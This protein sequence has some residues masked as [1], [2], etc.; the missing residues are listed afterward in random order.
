MKKVI[1]AVLVVLLAVA[2]VSASE[3]ELGVKTG[4]AFE[5]F[6]EK[7]NFE[8]LDSLSGKSFPLIL[9]VGC[10]FDEPHKMGIK[11]GVE[12]GLSTS[13][14]HNKEKLS[15]YSKTLFTA[16]PFVEFAYRFTIDDLFSIGTGL[17]VRYRTF[18]R[19]GDEGKIIKS[20]FDLIGDLFGEFGLNEKM[21]LAVG[22][23]L[24]L[25]VAGKAKYVQNF[26]SADESYHLNGVNFSIMPMVNFIY[27]I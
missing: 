21:S 27:K 25:G 11:A 18:G 14:S 22:A 1:L 5:W 20:T 3:V 24:G 8:H 6:K 12:F 4:F 15:E 10:Y 26:N 19:S 13:L 7:N 17:G 23:R 2:S 9:E 16:S